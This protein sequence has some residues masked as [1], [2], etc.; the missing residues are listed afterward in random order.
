MNRKA[1]IE[2]STAFIIKAVL[3]IIMI[4]MLIS[5]FTDAIEFLSQIPF[6]GRIVIVLATLFFF[7]NLEYILARIAM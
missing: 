4:A 3:A 5:F 2:L 6:L 1:S 7:Q